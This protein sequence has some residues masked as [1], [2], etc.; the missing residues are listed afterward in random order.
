MKNLLNKNTLNIVLIALVLVVMGCQC[1]K[2]RDLSNSSSSTPSSSPSTSDSPST[3]SSPGS[4][5]TSGK[6]DLTLDKYNQIKTGMT[7]K[8]IVD[9]IGS[10]GEETFSSEV[11]KYTI[12]SYKWDGGD[13]K[14]IFGTF[15]NDK[16]TSKSQSNLK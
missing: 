8:A 13:F 12:K 3:T 6:A 10:E 1:G 4:K 9:I 15:N 11:G 16:L 7:Y 14:Y 2:W 5:T